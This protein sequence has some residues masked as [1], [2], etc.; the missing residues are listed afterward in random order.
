M[1]FKNKTLWFFGLFAALLGVG[2]E[3]ELISRLLR[4]TATDTS[5][6]GSIIQGFSDGVATGLA[7]GGNFWANVWYN[8][9]HQPVTFIFILLLIIIMIMISLF[10]LWLAVVS[11]VGLIRNVS[12]ANKNKKTNINEGIGAGMANF[13]PVLGINV[14]LKLA[15]F[16]IF[17]GLGWMIMASV[18]LGY[19]GIIGYYVVFVIAAIVVLSLSFL[20][21]YQICYLILKKQGLVEALKSGWKLFKGYWLISLEMGVILLLI[22][23]AFAILSSLVMVFCLALPTA[24]LLTSMSPLMMGTAGVLAF[25]IMAVWF[26]WATSI[27]VSFGWSA[28][29]A[30]FEQLDGTGGVSK[31][32]RT[33]DIVANYFAEK[34]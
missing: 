27:M 4:Q 19:W 33:S 17:A 28:W 15:F 23:T 16:L 11:E 13:W 9:S 1:V 32:I 14:L 5:I 6:I 3:L 8:I 18:N 2:G 21:R 25:A 31:I 22:Y 26:L 7:V 10:L 29:V 30:L 20:F 24:A 12:L 34:R